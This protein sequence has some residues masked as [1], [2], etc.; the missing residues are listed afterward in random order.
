MEYRHHTSG[1]C[2]ASRCRKWFVAL[3]QATG[4]DNTSMPCG[5]EEGW[6]ACLGAL[7]GEAAQLGGCDAQ[8]YGY[9]GHFTVAEVSELYSLA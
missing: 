2:G 1:C 3:A 6:A 5:M 4:K 7:L 8:T 9:R